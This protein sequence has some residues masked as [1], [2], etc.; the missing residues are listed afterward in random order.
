[1]ALDHEDN[2]PSYSLKQIESSMDLGGFRDEQIGLVIGLVSRMGSLADD[3]SLIRAGLLTKDH[4]GLL[5]DA[6]F[7]NIKGV[8]TDVLQEGALDT[9]I[10]ID[11]KIH[12]LE[13]T[14]VVTIKTPET[15]KTPEL[16]LFTPDEL[17]GIYEVPL[18]WLEKVDSIKVLVDCTEVYFANGSI[19][20]SKDRTVGKNHPSLK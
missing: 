13:P 2:A 18:R 8:I 3:E 7:K 10:S 1:M 12:R 5:I 16:N 9:Y 14:R 11:A 19:A 6:D 4:V 17:R 20:C 15:S